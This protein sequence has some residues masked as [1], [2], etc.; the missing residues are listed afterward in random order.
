MTLLSFPPPGKLISLNDRLHWSQEAKLIKL[1]RE[2]GWGA[3]LEAKVRGLGPSTVQITLPVTARR[4]RDPSNLT[5]T[6]KAIVDGCVD[7]RVWVD[8]NSDWV[9]VFEP[10]VTIGGDV[11]VL[12]KPR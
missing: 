5:P 2:A 4:R 1:W 12:I 3:A 8:D 10:C 11:H 9:T 7:A 6:C